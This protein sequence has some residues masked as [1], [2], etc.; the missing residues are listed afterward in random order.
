MLPVENITWKVSQSNKNGLENRLILPRI[1]IRN[2]DGFQIHFV[3][4][5][6]K[7]RQIYES[8]NTENN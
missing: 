8:A 3:F 1:L 7:T 2:R 6:A 4:S 5:V